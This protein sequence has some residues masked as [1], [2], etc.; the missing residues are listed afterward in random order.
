MT[1]K[2]KKVSPG[3]FLGK[4]DLLA[5]DLAKFLSPLTEEQLISSRANCFWSEEDQSGFAL[6]DNYLFSVFALKKGK[7]RA[8]AAAAVAAGA[9]KLDC[10]GDHLVSLYSQVGFKVSFSAPWNQELAPQNWAYARFG[11]P[12]YYEMEL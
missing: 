12:N 11:K 3:F 1:K 9:Q 7:G 10:L 4:R 5:E 6:E 8:L 2:Y